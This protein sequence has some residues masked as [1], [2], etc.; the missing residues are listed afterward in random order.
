MRRG[1]EGIHFYPNTKS[2]QTEKVFEEKWIYRSDLIGFGVRPLVDSVFEVEWIL[3][4]RK[5]NFR[6][7]G[8]APRS[9]EPGTIL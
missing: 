8:P 3:Q 1:G 2:T 5:K 7:G 6:K 9:L 4:V